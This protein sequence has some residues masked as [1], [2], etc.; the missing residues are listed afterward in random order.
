LS[1]IFGHGVTG[2][3]P[4]QY[5][6]RSAL[7]KVLFADDEPGLRVLVKRFL[8]SR[9]DIVEAASG[10]EALALVPDATKIDLLITDEMMPEMEGHELSRRLRQ[11]NPDLRVLYLTGHSDHLFDKKDHLWDREAYLDK[12]FTQKSLNEAVALL[13]T[14]RLTFEA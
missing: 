4:T 12:P 6:E 8:D 10:K 9:F 5:T 2:D 14:G 13:M 7:L 3:P 11:Q 1:D